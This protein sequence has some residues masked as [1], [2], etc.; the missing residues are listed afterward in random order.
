[1]FEFASGDEF[2]RFRAGVSAPLRT[3]LERCT[4]EVREQI[5]RATV[6]AAAPYR[7]SDGSLRLPNVSI[8][9]A[10]RA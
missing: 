9:L 7:R 5:M 2:T 3:V 10:A 8:C 4:P 6:E 1:V